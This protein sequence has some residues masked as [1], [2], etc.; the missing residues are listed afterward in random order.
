MW[1]SVRC[2]PATERHAVTCTRDF[3]LITVLSSF[4][5]ALMSVDGGR[6]AWCA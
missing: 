3:V 6:P 1:R 4:V 5:S 2:S